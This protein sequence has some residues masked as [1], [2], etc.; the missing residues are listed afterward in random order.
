M[1]LAT[2]D[3]QIMPTVKLEIEGGFKHKPGLKYNVSHPDTSTRAL[4]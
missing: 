2:T 4:A 1:A 3:R